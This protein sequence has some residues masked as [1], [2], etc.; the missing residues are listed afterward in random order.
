MASSSRCDLAFT[1]TCTAPQGMVVGNGHLQ[2]ML[3]SPW[4]RSPVSFWLDFNIDHIWKFY[5][6][7]PLCLTIFCNFGH[8][9]VVMPSTSVRL[10]SCDYN[11]NS[12]HFL[13]WDYLQFLMSPVDLKKESLLNHRNL[14]V[15]SLCV[16]FPPLVT[17]SLLQRIQFSDVPWRK[18]LTSRTIWSINIVQ[19]CFGIAWGPQRLISVYLDDVMKLNIAEVWR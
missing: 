11:Y 6:S 12:D 9:S 10:I 2:G 7:I 19:L 5:D 4:G 1:Y 14:L 17:I 15:I 18:I 13:V 3:H 8:S 16:Q